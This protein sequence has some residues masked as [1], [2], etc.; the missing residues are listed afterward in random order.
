M[1]NV[2]LP[3]YSFTNVTV[4]SFDGVPDGT[5]ISRHYAHLGVTLASITT[6]PPKTWDAYARQFVIVETPQ[7]LVSIH[8]SG[9]VG[10]DALMGG[11]EVRFAHPQRYVSIDVFPFV[12]T[13]MPVPPANRPFLQA[14]RLK[15]GKVVDTKFL[16]VAFGDANYFDWHTLAIEAPTAEIERVVFSSVYVGTPH[17][18]GLFDQL[19]FSEEHPSFPP[20]QLG[21]AR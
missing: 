8:K 10:F 11:I 19:A 18:F 3:N 20:I 14:F 9:D 5:D 7:Y 12:I 6:A 17:V 1:A 13:E 16:P 15:D 4:I 21:P 2:T